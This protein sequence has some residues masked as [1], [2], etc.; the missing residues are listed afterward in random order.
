MKTFGCLLDG[1]HDALVGFTQTMIEITDPN[2][3]ASSGEKYHPIVSRSNEASERVNGKVFTLTESQLAQADSY[4]V[5][6]YK[7]E[8]VE[9]ASGRKA[10][11]YVKSE[12]KP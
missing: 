6:N 12:N 7:R 5:S 10:W 3:L 4:E 2:I 1:E 9:L 11:L 8:R